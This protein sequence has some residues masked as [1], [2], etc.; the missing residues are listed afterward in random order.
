MLLCT[1][2]ARLLPR[3]VTYEGSQTRLLTGGVVPLGG[4]GLGQGAGAALLLG[5]RCCLGRAAAWACH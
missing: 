3:G 4:Q 1:L 5:R 2:A